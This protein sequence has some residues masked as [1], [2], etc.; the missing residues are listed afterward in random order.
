MDIPRVM[1]RTLDIK[2]ITKFITI[3]GTILS[4]FF[5][6][7]IWVGLFYGEDI[8][9]FA[10]FD[11]LFFAINATVLYSL[12]EH[13]IEMQ[14]KGSIVAVNLIWILLGFAGAIPL[15]L[16]TPID[17]SSAFFESISGFT[18]TGATI[19][20]DIESLPKMI[21]FLRSL[22][23]WLGGM[24]IIVLGIGL[25]SIIN[26][27][28]SLS[29]FRAESTGI[30]MDKIAPKIRDTA[31]M[32]WGIYS[33]LTFVDMLLLHYFGMDWFDA[34]NHAFSTIST[35]G[36]ST[37]NASLG[38][39]D[40]SAVIWTTTIFM[41]L[42]GINFL[43][44]LKFLHRDY[45][46][47]R[48]EE[49]RYYLY[50]FLTLSLL[51]TWVHTL[52]SDMHLSQSLKHSFFTIASVLTTTGFATLNYEN[53]GHLVVSLVF[54]AMLIGGTT[55]STAGGIKVIRYIIIFKNMFTEVKRVLHPNAV[56]SIF[57]D[58]KKLKNSLL[59]SIAGFF[60]L[61][62]LTAIVVMLYL[63]ARG[64]DEMSSVS[65]ALATVGNIGPGFAKVGP[66]YNYGFFSWYDKLI[67]SIA[68]IIGR[69]ECYTIYLLLSREFWK[70][71]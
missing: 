64:L 41:I 54:I 27:T 61:Y 43:A 47:Y 53:W 15:M 59:T 2:G 22:T 19:F 45:S 13:K 8:F 44:H 3:T 26:P 37:K 52:S 28:G 5:I 9:A 49:I 24:G 68:M 67:L 14:I 62:V 20:S 17:F 66:I 56:L 63:Y 35:G 39:F 69:L 50:I 1:I 57:I 25:L 51:L 34:I 23:H 55:G 10:L 46:G 12:R 7:P 4:L 48:S 29:M 58:N 36:F 33:F 21:L 31:L 32:L 38:A 11:I 60:T 42:S 18:T 71:F 40:S 6:T 16:Y 65:T 30:S 70:R